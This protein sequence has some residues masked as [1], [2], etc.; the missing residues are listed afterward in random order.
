MHSCA[1]CDLK[2][3]NFIVLIH[4]PLC[5]DRWKIVLLLPIVHYEKKNKMLQ[6]E[7]WETTSIRTKWTFM[8]ACCLWRCLFI[9]NHVLNLMKWLIMTCTC[10]HPK[11]SRWYRHLKSV[12]FGFNIIF[13]K[14]V[15]PAETLKFLQRPSLSFLHGEK[16]SLYWTHC[17]DHP[18]SRVFLLIN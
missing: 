17:I 13:S 3:L 5:R 6:G 15:G 18:L 2:Q 12:F 11:R 1:P 4:F 9:K 8:C 7:Y 14:P 16:I 10:L